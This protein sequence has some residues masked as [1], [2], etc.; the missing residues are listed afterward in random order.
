MYQ[1]FNAWHDKVF[2]YLCM[3]KAAIWEPS[4]GYVYD[5]NEQFEQ[6]ML[7]SCFAKIK[8]RK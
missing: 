5:T 3:E 6:A 1:T 2:F 7:D 8:G 4:L